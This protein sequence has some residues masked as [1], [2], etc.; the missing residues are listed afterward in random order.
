MTSRKKLAIAFVLSWI[1]LAVAGCGRPGVIYGQVTHDGNVDYLSLG[2]FP[3]PFAFN[4]YYPISSG[5][6]V[7]Y[8]TL[9]DG[10]YYYPAYYEGF[11]PGKGASLA[12]QYTYTVSANPGGFFGDGQSSYFT[13]SLSYAGLVEEGA[14]ASLAPLSSKHASPQLGT[15]TWVQNGVSITVTGQIVQMTPDG[16]RPFT[17]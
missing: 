5:S 8:Y 11:G 14:V 15:H 2:G 4:V 12:Y 3:I 13:L 7:L 9:D 6:Y 1:V 17:Q 10:V 16:P